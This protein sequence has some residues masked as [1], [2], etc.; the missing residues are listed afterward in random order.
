MHTHI[1]ILCI[2]SLFVISV[3]PQEADIAIA[4]L[5]IIQMRERVVDFSK[6]FME[7]GISIMIRKPEKLKPGVFS[8]MAP[9]SDTVWVCITVGFLA[10]S[11]TLFLV[12]RFSPFEW[13]VQETGAE[14]QNSFNMRNTLWFTLGALMQQGSDISPRLVPENGLKYFVQVSFVLKTTC[15]IISVHAIFP[16][17]ECSMLLCFQSC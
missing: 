6:P 11:T 10:V 7:S 3:I 17:F 2:H 12:G 13:N 8:F 16:C 9:F 4:P 5:S 1:S 15:I 14:A